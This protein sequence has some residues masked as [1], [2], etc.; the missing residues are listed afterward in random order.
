MKKNFIKSVTVGIV[1]LS[2]LGGCTS[3]KNFM[4][5]HGCAGKNSCKGKKAESHNCSANKCSS[6]GCKGKK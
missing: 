1:G 2:L 4:S 3:V 5:K 6:N